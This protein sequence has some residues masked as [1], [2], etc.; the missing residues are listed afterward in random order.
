MGGHNFFSKVASIDPIAQ[1]VHAPGYNDEANYQ[2]KQHMPGSNGPY[3]GVTASLAGANAGYAAGG[4]G[5]NADWKAPVPWHQ[6]GIMG[7]LQGAASGADPQRAIQAGPG[8]YGLP[9]TGTSTGPVGQ[10]GYNDTSAS[11]VNAARNAVP[12]PVMTGTQGQIAPPRSF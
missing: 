1:A 9:N 7:A 2:L 6:G 12:R 5:A 10:S 4:P 8:A 11:Y 3:S